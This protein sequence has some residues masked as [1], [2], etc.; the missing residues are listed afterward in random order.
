MR[1]GKL[2]TEGVLT[3]YGFEFVGYDFVFHVVRVALRVLPNG[4]CRVVRHDS[5]AEPAGHHE[6]WT[7]GGNVWRM[8]RSCSFR[9]SR[10]LC[11]SD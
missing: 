1:I 9:A 7:G 8:Q 4:E 11:T 6:A 5:G 3:E 10:W 2:P